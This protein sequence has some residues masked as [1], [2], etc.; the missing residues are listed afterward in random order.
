MA[1]KNHRESNRAMKGVVNLPLADAATLPPP[2]AYVVAYN[3]QHLIPSF[4]MPL[5]QLR[6]RFWE[7]TRL[8]GIYVCDHRFVILG[9]SGPQRDYRNAKTF[10][11]HTPQ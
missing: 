3:V 4:S 2:T 8:A 10:P 5:F 6:G 7:S 11:V 1:I 9:G